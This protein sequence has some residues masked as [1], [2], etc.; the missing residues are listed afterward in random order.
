M[1][2]F[3]FCFWG[4]PADN[5]YTGAVHCQLTSKPVLLERLGAASA[6]AKVDILCCGTQ[7]GLAQ[8]TLMGQGYSKV[9]PY[10]VLR[11]RRSYLMRNGCRNR[12]QKGVLGGPLIWS[13]L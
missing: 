3:L 2:C 5:I 7:V 4:A 9:V 6:Q 10:V 12:C 8:P 11:A 13:I 1:R